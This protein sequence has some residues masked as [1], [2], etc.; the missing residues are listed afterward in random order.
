MGGSVIAACQTCGLGC[1]PIHGECRACYMFRR[2]NGHARP[3]RLIVRHAR[4][5]FE[6]EQFRALVIACKGERG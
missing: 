4:R 2:R 1:R 5:C 6:R 3:E